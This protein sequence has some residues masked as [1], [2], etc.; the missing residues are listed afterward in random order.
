MGAS[1]HFWAI[2]AILA[3]VHKENGCQLDFLHPD[4]EEWVCDIKVRDLRGSFFVAS[5]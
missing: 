5:V 4:P 2:L 1:F 3:I